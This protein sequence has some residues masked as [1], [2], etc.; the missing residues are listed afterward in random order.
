MHKMVHHDQ[1]KAEDD[2]GKIKDQ[3]RDNSSWKA[4]TEYAVKQT[5][6]V[7]RDS[8]SYSTED[9]RTRGVSLLAVEDKKV[10]FDTLIVFMQNT[11]YEEKDEVTLSDIKKTQKI[12]LLEK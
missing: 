7:S 9:E 1:L 5:L 6:I 12:T 2:K 10:N 4:T 3:V 8:S 11:E